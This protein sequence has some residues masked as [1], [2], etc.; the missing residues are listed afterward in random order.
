MFKKLYI[1]LVTCCR[2]VMFMS[3]GSEFAR[4][5]SKGDQLIFQ[6]RKGYEDPWRKHHTSAVT[7]DIWIYDLKKDE[8]KEVSTFNGEDREPVFSAD[9]QSFYYLSEKNGGSTDLFKKPANGRR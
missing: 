9:D 1:V 3:E 2:S 8:Y 4:F 6:D 7:R 5:N